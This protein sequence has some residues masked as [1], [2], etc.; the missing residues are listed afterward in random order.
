MFT[1]LKDIVDMFQ[2]N[3]NTYVWRQ[4]DLAF[5]D[6]K[7]STN[8]LQWHMTMD[9]LKSQSLTPNRNFSA[10]QLAVAIEGVVAGGPG[11]EVVEER[12]CVMITITQLVLV[13]T[14]GMLIYV[15]PAKDL[16]RSLHAGI[17]TRPKLNLLQKS[18]KL[19]LTRV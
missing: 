1:Y 5:R 18:D 9:H 3:P 19:T 10:S 12:K 11:E 17:R 6:L 15:S 2:L 7:Q 14:V 13:K 8:F 4:Y 16:I